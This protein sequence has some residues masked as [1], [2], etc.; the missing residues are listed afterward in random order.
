[1]KKIVRMYGITWAS[2]LLTL[3]ALNGLATAD[4]SATV[5]VDPGLF[6]TS[7]NPGCI[8]ENAP[9]PSARCKD[10]CL[11]VPTAARIRNVNYGLKEV[12]ESN[13]NWNSQPDIEILPSAKFRNYRVNRFSS[14]QEIC[15]VAMNWSRDRKREARIR[16]EYD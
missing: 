5:T 14:G 9:N 16:I 12:Y 4:E 8:G 3:T 10:V 7:R 13:F 6:T 15:A 11:L 1:M 2:I